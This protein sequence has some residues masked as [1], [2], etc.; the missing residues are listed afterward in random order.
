MEARKIIITG[1][2]TRIGAGI[3]KQLSGQNNE[4]LIHS[5][6]NI[7]KAKKVIIACN[8]YLDNLLGSIRN[9]FMPIKENQIFNDLFV[10]DVMNENSNLSDKNKN[11]TLQ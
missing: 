9:Y 1:G 4:I 7:I 6:S 2:A 3:A 5:G 8:G 11:K 10:F